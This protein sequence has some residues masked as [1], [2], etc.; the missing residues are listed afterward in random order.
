[1]VRTFRA[2]KMLGR[3]MGDPRFEDLIDDKVIAF[4]KKLDGKKGNDYNWESMVHGENVV[5]IDADEDLEEGIYVS[6]DDCD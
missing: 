2:Q 6:A 4:I 1:M 3:I 5:W